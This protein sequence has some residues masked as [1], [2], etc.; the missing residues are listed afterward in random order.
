[1][2][3]PGVIP[4]PKLAH[5]RHL[6]RTVT[7]LLLLFTLPA[8]LLA[9]C[10]LQTGKN[11]P[12]PALTIA[13]R[14]TE[15]SASAALAL[16]ETAGSE[17]FI[18]SLND[19]G[20]AHIF[21]F[22]PLSHNLLRLTDGPHDD[23]SPAVSPD[24]TQLAFASHRNN[25]WDLYLLDLKSGVLTQ[26]TNTPAYDGAPSWSPDGLWLAYETYLDDNL[27]IAILST[28]DH[29]QPPIRLT[30]DPAADH[31]PTWAPQGRQIAFVSNR[32]GN[33]EIWLANLDQT[34][35]RYVNLSNSPKSSETHPAWSPD[36][37]YLVWSSTGG[38]DGWNG[39]YLWDASQPKAAAHRIVEG[40]QAV[41]NNAGDR[42]M[43]YLR[44]PNEDFLNIYTLNGT[45]SLPPVR[46][47]N[48]LY[49]LSGQVNLPAP[50]PEPLAQA[51]AATPTP[52][53]RPATTSGLENQAGRAIIVPLNDVTAPTARL[54][55]AV[56]EAFV[57][58]RQQA[59]QTIGWNVMSN[60]ENAY[61][62][63]TTPLDP[64]LGEDW[65]YTGRS[66]TLNSVAL[67]AGWFVTVRED[68]GSQTYW[69]LYVR[70]QMQDGS[71]GIPLHDPPWD[72]NAR[73]ELD[74]ASYE[75]G[76]K[77]GAIPPGYWVDFTALARTYGWERLPALPN[78]RT[79]Y[80]GARP[81]QFVM[82]GGLDWYTAMLQVYPPEAIITPT[83]IA[84]PTRTP[85][86]TITPS[87]T[88]SPTRTP[89][90]TRTPTVAAPIPSTTPTVTP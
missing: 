25:Y 42:L 35:Q 80:R 48:A 5:S 55:D 72:L 16:A 6:R 14:M 85:T 2:T 87:P 63:L 13:A 70:A 43:V 71:Q 7:V 32:S 15:E 49:G 67:T 44:G 88:Q 22:D 21:A 83:E 38:E 51:V 47:P 77:Y 20:Y 40:N 29:N 75:Q 56:D 28:G 57:A 41:W 24:H 84:P 61:V 30:A 45:L 79:Y 76:G 66:F 18:L 78:W 36:G 64:G 69:R 12:L 9:A 81:T 86:P 19:N 31:S 23:L 89:L 73:Y 27:E 10:G 26:L 90:P 8:T 82:T 53:W 52:L 34:E 37:R 65:S 62:P 3:R 54:H 68:F 33:S 4:A 60:L 39:I 59:L 46:L 50:L 17:P 58:L 11:A 74:V 1:M